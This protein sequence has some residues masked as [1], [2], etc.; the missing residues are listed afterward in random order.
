MITVNG[1]EFNAV[2]AGIVVYVVDGNH[3]YSVADT[4]KALGISAEEVNE[5]ARKL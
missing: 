3:Y 1:H 2:Y 5:I 4:A